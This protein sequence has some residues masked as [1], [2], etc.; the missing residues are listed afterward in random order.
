[1]SNAQ[2]EHS[3]SHATGAG[4][5]E[6]QAAGPR[7]FGQRLRLLRSKRNEDWWSIVFGGPLGTFLVAFVADVPW[8]TPNLI[9]W[10]G[11]AVKLLACP[12]L[13][14]GTWQ[15]DVTAAV[16]LQAAVV[17]D[18]MDGSLARYRRRPSV[19]GAFL[20]KVTDAIGLLALSAALGC[21]VFAD[22]GDLTALLLAMLTGVS[23]VARSYV[24]WVVA[25]FEKANDVQPTTGPATR[26]DF[27]ELGFGA[28]MRYY[29]ASTPRILYVGEA[30]IYLWI[31]V[32][33]MLGRLREVAYFL[34]VML[35]LWF[36]II[37]VHR[38]R[39]VLSIDARIRARQ[40]EQDQAQG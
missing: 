31:G 6:A 5:G 4:P 14:A 19:L 24:Y 28:R 18:S 21:R 27:G 15:G 12:V 30:D 7:S 40:Q 29:L 26:Q 22:T 1:M 11:F 3:R 25:Y 33:L 35:G 10:V 36:V 2:T 16:L 39:T 32:G 17:L 20:D 13:L 9:T 37:L 38:F 34:G 23:Y 8:I